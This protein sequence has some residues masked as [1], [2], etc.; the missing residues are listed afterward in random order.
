MRVQGG[1]NSL[2]TAGEIIVDNNKS[3]IFFKGHDFKITKG[4][5]FFR[6]SS[7]SLDP[8]FD[9]ISETKISNYNLEMEINGDVKNLSVSFRSDPPLAENDILSLLTL[10]ITLIHLGSC[11]TQS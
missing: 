3:K 9:I 10:G 2:K 4:N 5:V 1:E 11:R 6:E 7:S 8:Y